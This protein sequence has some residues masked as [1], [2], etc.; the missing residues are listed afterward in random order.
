MNTTM[1]SDTEIKLLARLYSIILSW[2][3]TEDTAPPAM[4]GSE[5]GE[6]AEVQPATSGECKDI[7][8]PGVP[9]DSPV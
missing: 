6:A 9:D 1:P 5:A 7:V 3:D 2:P 8:S 4:P